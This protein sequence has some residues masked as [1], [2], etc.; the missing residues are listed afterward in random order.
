LAKCLSKFFVRD[1]RPNHW[2]M[3][4][5]DG[6]HSDVWEIRGLRWQ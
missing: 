2:Y 6:R 3:H 5:F 4:A 1:P